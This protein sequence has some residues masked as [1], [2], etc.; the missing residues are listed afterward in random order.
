[1]RTH[2]FIVFL[3]IKDSHRYVVVHCTDIDRN[4]QLLFR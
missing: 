1:M 4:V 2:I 3:Y